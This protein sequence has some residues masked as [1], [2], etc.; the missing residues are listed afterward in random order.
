MLLTGQLV[1][2]IAVGAL[3]GL[4][5]GLLGIGGGLVVVPALAMTFTSMHMDAN[6]MQIATATSLAIM[7]FTTLSSTFSHARKEAI[8]WTIGWHVGIGVVAGA[9][10]GRMISDRLASDH[11]GVIFVIS[12]FYIALRMFKPYQ[13]PKES[14]EKT[15]LPLWW[16]AGSGIGVFASLLGLGGGV[17]MVPFL[18]KC[19]Q[20]MQRA[21]AIS[22]FSGFLV[23]VASTIRACFLNPPEV[24]LDHMFGQIYWPAWLTISIASTLAAPLGVKL[25]HHLPAAKLKKVFAIFLVFVSLHML[26]QLFKT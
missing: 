1:L 23:A 22:C 18:L 2:F 8:D 6:V 12:V 25:A 4:L 10:I 26:Y 20:P 15:P 16:L 24:V 7:V 21:V 11:L 19:H 14:A 13:A 17:L 9:L 3:A 5:S